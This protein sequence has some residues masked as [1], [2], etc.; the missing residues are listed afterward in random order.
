MRSS[1]LLALLASTGLMAGG[2]AYAQ[3]GGAGSL[4]TNST[5]LAKTPDI[6]PDQR[7]LRDDVF[8]R[9]RPP[10]KTQIVTDVSGVFAKLK[11]ACTVTDARLVAKGRAE[12]SGQE[13]K[14]YE[15][16]CDSGL[17]YFVVSADTDDAFSCFAAE[18][19]RDK[20]IAAGQAPGA[21]CTLPANADSMPP[22]CAGS[23]LAPRRRANIPKWRAAKVA[24]M[25]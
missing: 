4:R 1:T 14:T 17:G 3:A 25:C 11:I 13:T 7:Q 20:D 15:A 2:L 9:K 16:T 23:G 24:A 10:S 18:A 6:N 5:D 21:V 12:G 19:T 22:R 8:N